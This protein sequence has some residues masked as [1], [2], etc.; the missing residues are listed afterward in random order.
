M[1]KVNLIDESKLK[2]LMLDQ[3]QKKEVTSIESKDLNL[4]LLSLSA[5]SHVELFIKDFAKTYEHTLTVYQND[6]GFYDKVNK[7]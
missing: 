5:K 1:N 3:G 6:I 7:I 2:E 4:G